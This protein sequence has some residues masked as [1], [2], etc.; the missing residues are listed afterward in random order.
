MPDHPHSLH[1]NTSKGG[2]AVKKMMDPNFSLIGKLL[3]ADRHQELLQAL[4]ESAEANERTLE[5]EAI[6]RLRM[7]VH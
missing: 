6:Y 3:K 1:E 4:R 7:T 2:I 5:Q